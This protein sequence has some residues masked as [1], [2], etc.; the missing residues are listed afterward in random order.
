MIGAWEYQDPELMAEHFLTVA[1]YNLQHP[2]QFT[3]EAIAGLRTAFIE[4]LDN[5]TAASFIRQRNAKAYE[6]KKRVTRPESER[7]PV[8]RHWKMT[9]A[10][11]YLPDQ[12]QGAAGRVWAWAAAIRSQL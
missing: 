4:R 10:D 11:V 1:G 6:G 9:I 7:H 3:D 8:L 12:P 5:G 2:A